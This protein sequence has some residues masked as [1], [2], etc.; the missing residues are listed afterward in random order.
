MNIH[1][2][3]KG[4]QSIFWQ[5]PQQG[6]PR[7]NLKTNRASEII[8]SKI[9]NK[10][11][12]LELSEEAI[13]KLK[14]RNLYRTEKLENKIQEY[15]E[16]IERKEKFLT[17]VDKTLDE[18]LDSLK[19]FMEKTKE[20]IN[21][22]EAIEESQSDLSP[23]ELLEGEKLKDEL[24]TE[25]NTIEDRMKTIADMI[26]AVERMK[27]QRE[28]GTY[29]QEGS[30]AEQFRNA[31]LINNFAA[32]TKAVHEAKAMIAEEL[33]ELYKKIAEMEE[34][35]EKMMQNVDAKQLNGLSEMKAMEILQ[36][37]IANEDITALL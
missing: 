10:A 37:F 17:E 32:A 9:I 31:D 11:V 16:S 25:A 22:T 2:S 34:D 5:N 23:N 12:S 6:Y 19:T 18:I 36:K 21:P 14:I 1:G 35:I 15:Y 27:A 20:E 28:G 29:Q 26:E 33:D 30:L 4:I 7:Q 13:Q 24:L 8:E 3:T